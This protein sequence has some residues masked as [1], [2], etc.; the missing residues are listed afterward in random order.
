MTYIYIYA[1]SRQAG[2]ERGG[3]GWHNYNI[4]AKGVRVQKGIK[5]LSSDCHLCAEAVLCRDVLWA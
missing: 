1:P 3:R 5:F 2:R 4:H